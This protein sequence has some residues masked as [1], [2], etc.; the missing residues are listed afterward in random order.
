MTAQP[1]V[2][3]PAGCGDVGA[4][5]D[6]ASIRV[7]FGVA[8]G[9]IHQIREKSTFGAACRAHSYGEPARTEGSLEDGVERPSRTPP[10]QTE[11]PRT[12]STTARQP[13]SQP[14]ANPYLAADGAAVAGREEPG[15]ADGDADE[16]A[17]VPAVVPAESS[18][19][20]SPSR[21]V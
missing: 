21:N 14:G 3:P 4:G 12:L 7:Q 11:F 13:D 6:A 10:R 18:G 1:S 19:T 5:S 9:S 20:G 17:V 15:I 16:A 2:D 8:K